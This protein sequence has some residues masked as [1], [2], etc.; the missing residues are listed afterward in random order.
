MSWVTKKEKPDGT[1]QWL[2]RWN[3]D[4]RRK[5]KVIPNAKSRRAAQKVQKQWDVQRQILEEEP[6]PK[7]CWTLGESYDALMEQ[8]ICS[9]RYENELTRFFEKSLLRY[10]GKGKKLKD[11]SA[12]E[13]RKWIAWRKKQKGTTGNPIRNTTVRHEF[14]ALSE[15]FQLAIDFGIVPTNPCSGISL[16]KLLPNDSQRRDRILTPEE[17]NKLIDHSE[18]HIKMFVIL[19]WATAGRM[20]E[21]L[22]LKWEDLDL[23]NETVVF[24]HDPPE[25]R[26]K[27]KKTHK[28]FVAKKFLEFIHDNHPKVKNSPWVFSHEDGARIQNVKKGIQLTTKR[29]GLEGVSAHTIRH[30]TNSALLAGGFSQTVVRDHVGHSDFRMTSHYAHS[31]QAEKKSA[32]EYLSQIGDSAGNETKGFLKGFPDPKMDEKLVELCKSEE[33]VK[34][35]KSMRSVIKRET[36]FEPATLS[37]GS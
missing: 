17:I 34:S 3:E 13:I 19:A 35:V 33:F 15:C 5:T 20:S 14:Y 8:K 27:S 9:P 16:K 25:R 22:Q 23:T 36:G 24:V 1:V 4:G 26:T 28:V 2:Y 7:K 6:L 11:I 10:F 37:L 18:G 32:A 21:I 31:H 29:A 12:G 30:S